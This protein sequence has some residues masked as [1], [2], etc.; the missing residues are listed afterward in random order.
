MGLKPTLHFWYALMWVRDAVMSHKFLSWSDNLTAW[1]SYESHVLVLIW[2]SDCVV[3]LWVTRVCPDL[4]IWLPDAVTS[5]TCLSWS[6]YL[7]AWCC[8]ESHVLVLIW[9]SDCLMQ[10][11]V[12]RACP[13]LTI[14][15]SGTVMSHTCLSW[16]DYLTAWCSYE[17]HVLVLIWL[18]DCVVQLWVTRVCPDLTIWLPDAVTSHTCLSWSDYLTA[19]CSYGHTCLSWSDY[20]TAWC[21]YESHVLVLIWLS[22]CVVQ[23]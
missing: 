11:R 13:D 20:L 23:F 9:L 17:S 18:S 4:T 8:Y 5:H 22:D 19:W 2:L 15:L 14:W 3:Q 1:C 10:L 6:D 7:T 12:T 16:S 21:S